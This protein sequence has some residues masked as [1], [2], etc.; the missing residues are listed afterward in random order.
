MTEGSGI[1]KYVET[2]NTDQEIVGIIR[3]LIP[4]NFTAE[5]ISKREI[6]LQAFSNAEN[7]K[8]IVDLI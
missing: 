4:L 3:K 1:E 5:E 8:K 2:G 7:A 6:L